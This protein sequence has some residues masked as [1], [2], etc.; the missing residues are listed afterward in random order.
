MY[1]IQ[2]QVFRICKKE[3]NSDSLCIYSLLKGKGCPITCPACT[4]GRCSYK[5]SHLNLCCRRARAVSITLT[6]LPLKK[7]PSTHFIRSRVG[8]RAGLE[9]SR[10]SGLHRLQTLHHQPVVSCYTDY[11]ILAT[12]A[13]NMLFFRIYHRLIF[14]AM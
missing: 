1:V 13:L 11:V 3:K 7:T 12:C 10:R 14:K 5:S 9:G 8:L 6:A 4:E 2:Q